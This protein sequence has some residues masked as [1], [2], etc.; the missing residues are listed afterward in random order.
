MVRSIQKDFNIAAQD[1]I[2]FASDFD[3]AKTEKFLQTH[4]IGYKHVLGNY[5]GVNED[6]YVINSLDVY[7]VKTIT[8]LQESVI[9]LS[10]M[11]DNEMREAYLI[12]KK[13]DP[14]YLGYFEPV[15][16]AEALAAES[17]MFNPTNQT[18]FIARP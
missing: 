5:K 9:Y 1:Y 4:G 15:K 8:R 7:K 18:F 12:Y 6:S 3:K 13:S 16:P 17:Y 14:V 11:R 10:E 2:I